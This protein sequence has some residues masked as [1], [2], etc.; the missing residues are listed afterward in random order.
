ML[1]MCTFC[2]KY[3]FKHLTFL[4][5]DTI[6]K[7]YLVGIL[8]RSICQPEALDF[9][10]NKGFHSFFKVFYTGYFLFVFGYET[11]NLSQIHSSKCH[12]KISPGNQG[13]LY[14]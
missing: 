10:P 5:N 6:Q 2:N 14:Y 4:H 7:C 8:Y 1:A 13:H 9:L 11:C 3:V 12:L